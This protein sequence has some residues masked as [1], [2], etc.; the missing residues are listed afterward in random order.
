LIRKAT[1][2]DLEVLANIISGSFRDVATRFSLTQDNCPK[3]PSNC[4]T[5]WIEADMA[6]GVQYFI[7]SANGNPIGCVG[8]EFPG[9]DVCYLERLC[10]LP[11]MR[12]KHFGI[13]L[14]RHALSFA[15]AKGIRKASIGIIAEHAELKEWYK[16]FGFTE[17]GTRNFPHLPFQVCFMELSLQNTAN[18][19]F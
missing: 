11:E 15:A 10:V 18:Q 16:T 14:V 8:I 3:H 7:L 1:T 2:E 12:G 4:T 5:S 13:K 6:R 19:R 17:V 9:N